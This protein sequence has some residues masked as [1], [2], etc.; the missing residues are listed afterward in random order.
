MG[1]LHR[2]ESQRYKFS[3]G[4]FDLQN[5]LCILLKFRS[6]FYNLNT[7]QNHLL[8]PPDLDY[9]YSYIMYFKDGIKMDI[10]LINLKDLNRY[11]SDSDGL[12]KI[13]VDKDNLVIQEIVPDDSNY[14]LKKPTERE[15][16]DCCNEFWSVS[17]YVAKGV[18]RREILFALDHF[19]N[20]LRPELLRMI[21]WYIGFNRGFDFSLGKN[22][23]FI[24]KYL[25]D[26]EF[27]MFLA[28]FEMNGYR[29]TYQSFKL[30]C[31]LFKYYSN[32]V[33]CLGNYNYPNYE[34]NIE[35]FIRNNYEN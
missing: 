31:E 7:N 4:G 12:V 21:S 27:N 20:I 11:F 5:F 19:N 13:L 30:C 10:T 18:F 28:T 35:N 3:S 8:F 25:T 14:W 34:K 9:G 15:F 16:Y 22:Y 33:S 29:K 23:K 17:T 26:K 24:N 32:K 1:L 2:C 6:Q